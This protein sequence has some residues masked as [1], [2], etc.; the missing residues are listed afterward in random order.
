MIYV[1]E[2]EVRVGFMEEAGGDGAVY[3]DLSEGDV[4]IQPQGLIHYQQN[5]GC[6]PST[7]IAALNH[8]DPGTVPIAA[9]FFELPREAV[10]AQL[11]FDNAEIKQ[12]K[13]HLP[14]APV[15]AREKCLDMCRG[16]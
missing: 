12:F 10:K 13:D 5:L 14:L 4:T 1:V 16:V 3:N 7:F 2:G 8:E 9:S 15:M 11:A 6:K